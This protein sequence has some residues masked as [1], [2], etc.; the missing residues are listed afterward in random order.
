MNKRGDLQMSFGWLFA[1]IAGAFI[2]FLA[3]Y[4]TVK[5]IG[6]SEE[7]IDTE[8]AAQ[9]GVLLNPLETGYEDIISTPLENFKQETRITNECDEGDEIDEFGSQGIKASRKSFGGKWTDSINTVYFKNK[10]LFSRENVEGKK[11]YLLSS[12]LHYPFKVGSVIVLTSADRT[13]CFFDAPEEVQLEIENI[14]KN[15]EVANCSDESIKICFEKRSNCDIYVEYDKGLGFVEKKGEEERLFFSQNSLMYGAIFS[16]EKIYECQVKRLMNRVKILSQIYIEKAN[17]V[18]QKDCNSNVNTELEILKLA[19][20]DFQN[21]EDIILIDRLV[22]EA[23]NKNQN[24][25][26]KIW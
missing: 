22:K 17:F 23:Q 15:I 13:Y 2:L 5:I 19:I 25:I 7:E 26:C 8:T 11:F 1:L 4:V 16:D 12:G 14:Q 24:P 3:I 10:Y 18:E 21:S 9:I 20:D 6:T